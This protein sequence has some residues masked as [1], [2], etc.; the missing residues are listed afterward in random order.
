MTLRAASDRRSARKKSAFER[1]LDWSSLGWSSGQYFYS[2]IV[3]RLVT[4]T[5]CKN[6][7]WLRLARQ[8]YETLVSRRKHALGQ[9]FL[10]S[11]FSEASA[12]RLKVPKHGHF[13]ANY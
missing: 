3:D 2:F 6:G 4:F 13:H 12:G 1:E 11:G 7:R 5:D 10:N 9:F 8:I